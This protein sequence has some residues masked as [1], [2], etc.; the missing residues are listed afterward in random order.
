VNNYSENDQA[1][2][3]YLNQEPENFPPKPLMVEKTEHSL[4]RSLL[5]LAIYFILFYIL[6]EQNVAYI[7]AILVVIIVHELGHLAAM[8]Y[9]HYSNVKIFILPLIGALTGGKKQR[10]SQSQ[11]S[12]ILL[13][14]P[15]PGL[16]IA[17]G[18]YYLNDSMQNENL[19]MLANS[20][21][22]INLF[23]LLPI[24]PL[25]GGKLMET[26]FFK[27]H[28]IL[29]LIFGILSIMALAV[30]F[31]FSQSLIMLIVPVMMGIELFN[32][33][34]NEKIREY[35]NQEQI[36]YK[37]E[38]NAISDKAYWIIR[39]CVLFSFSRK[40]SGIP[41]G[42]YAYSPM[43]PI[44]MQHVSNVLQLNMLNDL[45]LVKKILFILT[46]LICLIA[47]LIIYSLHY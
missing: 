47:P 17:F 29:R 46:Y 10:V 13:A 34:K 44:L 18:L 23:N 41:P 22:F 19:K 30:I 6:F 4:M 11:L 25:D 31:L 24:Y 40:F 43:E 9:Y 35:L 39:D 12:I 36:N 1:G 32:E 21:L 14:G 8:R 45:N 7:A 33:H 37:N 3:T 2:D 26:L 42:Q 28:H 5:S 16:I 20:F 27:H 38:Y 15:L